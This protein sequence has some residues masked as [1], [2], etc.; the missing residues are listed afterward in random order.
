[1]SPQVACPD[2][3]VLAIPSAAISE[4]ISPHS[5]KKSAAV[6]HR[7]NR[8]TAGSPLTDKKLTIDVTL[9]WPFSYIAPSGFAGANTTRPG[10]IRFSSSKLQSPAPLTRRR[11]RVNVPHAGAIA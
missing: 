4:N 2:C 9:E 3:G 1:M 7:A 10:Q 8:P 6:H 5:Q 11:G